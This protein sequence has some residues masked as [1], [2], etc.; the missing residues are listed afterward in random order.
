MNQFTCGPDAAL[1]QS[2]GNIAP[3]ARTFISSTPR[4][5]RNLTLVQ[6]WHG[7]FFDRHGCPEYNEESARFLPDFCVCNGDGHG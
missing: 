5:V 4:E 6:S 3:G 1:F 7:L 2:D